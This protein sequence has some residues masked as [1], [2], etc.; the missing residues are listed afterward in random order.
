MIIL[1]IYQPD[2]L[3][4][5]PIISGPESPSQRLSCIL[6]MLLKPIVPH[7]ITYMKDDWEYIKFLHRSL[8]FYSDMHSSDLEALL[9]QYLLNLI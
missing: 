2:D 7:L 9:F 4:G 5:R 3:K 1:E 6:K 8:N